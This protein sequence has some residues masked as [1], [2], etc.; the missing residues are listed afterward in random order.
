MIVPDVNLLEYA[1]H[2]D[3]PNCEE[4]RRLSTGLVNGVETIG[5]SWSDSY[6]SKV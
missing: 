2:E 5:E 6:A 1:Y 3:D 4:A